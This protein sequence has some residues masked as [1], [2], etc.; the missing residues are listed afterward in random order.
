MMK[1]W[2]GKKTMMLCYVS[3]VWLS[4]LSTSFASEP[5]IEFTHVPPRCSTVDTILRG[6][7]E[8]V[9]PADHQVA[10]Y[11]FIPYAPYAAGWWTKPSFQDPLVPI[12]PDGT[13]SCNIVTGGIDETA[14]W[15]K[16]FFVRDGD[17]PPSCGPCSE[18]PPK[19]EQYPY[20]EVKRPMSRT[21]SFSG[22]DWEVKS[23]CGLN[24]QVDPGPNYFSDG[25]E[26][27]R[28]DEEGQ[29]HLTIKKR[30][31]KWHCTEVFT[32]ESLGYGK[33]IFRLSSRVDQLDKNV[34]LGLFT[35]DDIAPQCNYREIDIEFS[36]WGEVTDLNAQYVVQPF[37]DP[38]NIHKFPIELE[39]EKSTHF[40][41]WSRGVIH[42][43][44]LNGHPDL[45]PAQEDIIESWTY[46]LNDIPP[47]GKENVHINL[48]LFNGVPPSDGKDAEV[49]IKSFE[50]I[51]C[52]ECDLSADGR[53]DMQDWLLFGEDWG[54]TD[55][56]DPGI[57]CECDLNDDGRC[58][59]QDWLLFGEDWGRT[60]CP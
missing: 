50:F 38:E 12:S 60:D 27:V 55:C 13:W 36:R 5:A 44:S 3:L 41:N 32:K 31:T 45:P 34:V 30:D 56:H 23:M 11:I 18:L 28:V 52:C 35:W 24:I 22:Y 7:V 15:I 54:H 20:A 17:T 43:Q 2:S 53:C 8:N 48:W 58:D 19:L 26:D 14:T 4:I 16:A 39:D 49:I 59:M 51:P 1:A 46:T 42:F 21:I 37:S 9:N 33:Y 25:E 40:F 29:L 6:L 57:E 47:E 10:V